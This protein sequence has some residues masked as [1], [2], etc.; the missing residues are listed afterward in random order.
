[1]GQNNRFAFIPPFS[2]GKRSGIASALAKTEAMLITAMLLQRFRID[3]P[4]NTE[5]KPFT[6]ILLTNRPDTKWMLIR[7]R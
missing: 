4:P 3:L 2:A 6:T 7:K 1:M 5:V